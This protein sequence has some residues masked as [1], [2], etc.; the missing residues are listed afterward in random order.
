MMKIKEKEAMIQYLIG[1]LVTNTRSLEYYIYT[2]KFDIPNF[3]IPDEIKDIIHNVV[4]IQKKSIRIL[5]EILDKR[6]YKRVLL[7][8]PLSAKIMGERT[9]NIKWIDFRNT[10]SNHRWNDA[11]LYALD[12]IKYIENKDLLF[13]SDNE[14]FIFEVIRYET[15]ILEVLNNA[16]EKRYSPLLISGSKSDL[17]YP[18]L[19]SNP[20]YHTYDFD[21][22]TLIAK[23]RENDNIDIELSCKEIL[24]NEESNI[25]TYISWHDQ[26]VR[27]IKVSSLL[28]KLIKNV[29][30]THL[31]KKLL[32][33]YF[34]QCYQMMII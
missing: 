3:N 25:L 27:T 4:M 9:L 19:M 30:P 6:L 16:K 18:M 33:K 26:K 31:I 1:Y 7:F 2:Q 23:L 15:S 12:F 5:S 11:Y 8:F 17:G 13:Y 32:M 21:I 22:V 14:F 29:I 28:I 24:K 10:L 20:V 34:H